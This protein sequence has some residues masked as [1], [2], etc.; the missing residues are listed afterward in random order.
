[1]GADERMSA[2]E[3]LQD[4]H[5]VFE[6]CLRAI[7]TGH[8]TV[9]DCVRRYPHIPELGALLETASRAHS[10]PQPSMPVAARDQ[11]RAEIISRHR[12]LYEMQQIAPT[13]APSTVSFWHALSPLRLMMRPLL[14]LSIVVALFFGG[15]VMFIQAARD[16]V[17][18]DALY[19]LKL[20]VEDAEVSFAEPQARPALLAHIARVRLDE[21]GTLRERGQIISESLIFDAA[22][23]INVAL[24]QAPSVEERR[25][26]YLATV[27]ELQLAVDAGKVDLDA[28]RVAVGALEVPSEVRQTATLSAPASDQAGRPATEVPIQ[29]VVTATATPTLKP[30]STPR[31]THTPRPTDE[32]EPTRT[33]RP[34]RTPR[35]TDEPEPTRTVRPSRTPRPTNEPEPTRTVRPTRTPRAGGNSGNRGN[36]GDHGNSGNQGKGNN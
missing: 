2:N 15:G 19:G 10:L 9:R 25:A 33:V 20:A 8:A 4:E 18:G 14:A 23:Q 35:P 22:D 24:L 31:P 26:L 13:V 29:L 11:L 36:S 12:I 16:T 6:A 3:P 7:L 34:S 28:A 30:T 17:P 27:Q 32:P 5:D 21:V 1:M